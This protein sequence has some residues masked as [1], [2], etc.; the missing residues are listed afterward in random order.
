MFHLST[1]VHGVYWTCS[2]MR[3]AFESAV[4]VS[5]MMGVVFVVNDETRK[6]CTVNYGIVSVYQKDGMEDYSK[7][8]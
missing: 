1:L 7:W 5:R 2:D 3:T 4:N 8:K 6:S